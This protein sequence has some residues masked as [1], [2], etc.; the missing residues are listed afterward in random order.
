MS[1][2]LREAKLLCLKSYMQPNRI[3]YLELL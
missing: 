3:I 1:L 2:L